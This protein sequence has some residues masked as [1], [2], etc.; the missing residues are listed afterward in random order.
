MNIIL[1]ST[2]FVNGT[3][4][5]NNG[6][7]RCLTKEYKSKYEWYIMLWSVDLWIFLKHLTFATL[8]S[9]RHVHFLRQSACN[10]TWVSKLIISYHQIIIH[11]LL[12]QSPY[13]FP[14]VFGDTFGDEF[15]DSLNFV[16]K[17]VTHLVMISVNHC[18]W[19]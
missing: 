17:L 13:R 15:G 6:C 9:F 3:D 2:W 18:I 19:W 4:N 7:K 16:S 1:K 14:R 5:T 10:I 12:G 11:Y 8:F